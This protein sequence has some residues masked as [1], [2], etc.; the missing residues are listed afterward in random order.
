[1]LGAT[2][3]PLNDE[4]GAKA[5][6]L[7][8][9]PGAGGHA[10]AMGG[11]PGSASSS[12]LGGISGSAAPF[13]SKSMLGSAAHCP[14]S[15]SLVENSRGV[16]QDHRQESVDRTAREA[17]C[18]VVPLEVTDELRA[19]GAGSRAAGRP[20][21]GLVPEVADIEAAAARAVAASARPGAAAGDRD[22]I[23][24]I[25][26]G[27]PPFGS[28]RRG[29][30]QALCVG[31]GARRRE[32]QDGG[33]L[34]SPGLWPP[35]R[36]RF[37]AAPQVE[38]VRADVLEVIRALGPSAAKRAVATLAAGRPE[39]SPFRASAVEGLRRRLEERLLV[40]GQDCRARAGPLR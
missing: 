17:R 33:G 16:Q 27:A 29:V 8:Y 11:S 9:E 23:S 22:D 5:S 38:A 1:M 13:A 26:V 3:M 31:R 37:A 18:P 19:P 12:V 10:V 15:I 36:R 24:D 28:G 34:C 4:S 30:G 40:Q 39:S 6:P 25:D 7:D 20:A 21:P 14:P 2:A 32:L 35:H